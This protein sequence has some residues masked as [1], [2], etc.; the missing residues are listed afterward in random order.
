SPTLLEAEVQRI[1]AT[2]RAPEMLAEIQAALGHDPARFANTFAKPIL[3]ERLLRDKFDNDDAFHAATRRA[4]E[5]VRARLLA[6][7]TNGASPAQLLAHLQCP[8]PNA[9]TETTWQLTPRPAQTNAPAAAELE[10]RKRFGPNAQR[11][12]SP[13]ELHQD[14]NYYFDDLPLALQNVLRVQ[15]RRPGDVSAVIETPDGFLLYL[16]REKS[17]LALGVA[18]LTVPKRSLEQWLEETH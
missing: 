9:V 14:R 4:C 7:K 1:H 12:A 6:A 17:D 11:L 10:I 16:A 18:C 13:G 2:T 3:V 5:A 8:E 15:L